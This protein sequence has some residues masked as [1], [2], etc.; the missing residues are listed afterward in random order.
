MSITVEFKDFE[1]MKGFARELL[2][3]QPATNSAPEPVKAAK[4]E[5]PETKTTPVEQKTEKE[6]EKNTSTAPIEQ[7]ESK[8]YS[9]EEVR[10]KLADL[11]KSGKRTQVKELLSSFGVEKLSE[12][13]SEHYSELME[14]AEVL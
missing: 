7:E 13:V 5:K 10:A 11:N 2:G 8:T 12:I 1:E 9:L 14:K 4:A 3:G 6:P